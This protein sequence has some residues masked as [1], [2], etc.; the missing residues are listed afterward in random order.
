MDRLNSKRELV[1]SLSPKRKNIMV[2]SPIPVRR[3]ITS[4]DILLSNTQVHKLIRSAAKSTTSPI[5]HKLK[6]N[7]FFN[8]PRYLKPVFEDQ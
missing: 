4:P 2:A 6:R 8:S 7:Q 3:K 1:K 5:G